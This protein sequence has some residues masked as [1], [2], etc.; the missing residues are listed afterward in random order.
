MPGDQPLVSVCVPT[1]N[2]A[3]YLPRAV[4]SVLDQSFEDFELIVIDDASSDDTAEVMAQYTDPRLTF[5]PREENVGLFANFNDC[6]ERARGKY[7]KYLCADDWFEPGILEQSVALLEAEPGLVVATTA[8]WIVDDDGVRH[9]AHEPAFG[10]AGRVPAARVVELFKTGFNV[11]GMPTNA[12]IRRD[13]FLAVGGFDAAFAP[14]ADVHLWLKLLARG[15][16]GWL[17]E[18]LCSIRVHAGHSHEY[19]PDPNEASLRIWE[20]AA[21]RDDMPVAPNELQE[22]IDGETVNFV[23]FAARHALSGR[24]DRARQLLGALDGHTSKARAA[25]CFVRS[26]PAVL[27]GGAVRAY[28]SRTG[29]ELIY[30]PRPRAGA[31]LRG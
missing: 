8:D 31:K 1:Y 2:Y 25:L 9:G 5:I 29:R 26:A 28:A 18:R 30:T 13:D 22:A 6:A 10:P 23:W 16:F 3:R 7:L 11:I 14:A 17:P 27:Y 19:A 24:F 12:T 15:D 4:E 20:D 21:A